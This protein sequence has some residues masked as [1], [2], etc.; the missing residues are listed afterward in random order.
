MKFKQKDNKGII[1]SV[2]KIGLESFKEKTKNEN[3]ISQKVQDLQ[4]SHQTIG[5]RIKDL[6]N[7][8]K[9]Q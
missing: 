7:N 2:M 3:G 4:L 1:V 5:S 9:D 6:S 8:I